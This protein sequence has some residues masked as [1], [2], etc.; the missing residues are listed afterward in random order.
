MTNFIPIITSDSTISLYN[1]VINDVYHSNVGAYTEALNKYTVPSGILEFVKSN[2]SVHIL[3]VCFGLGYNSKVAISEIWKINPNC[4]IKVTAIEIDPDVLALSCFADN[5][6]INSF[7]SSAFCELISGFININKVLN[8]LVED[9]KEY[10]YP[11]VKNIQFISPD[12]LH[13]FFK[14]INKSSNNNKQPFQ[15]NIYYK[16]ISYR[17]KNVEHLSYNSNL[18]D[19]ELYICDF[20]D[21]VNDLKPGYD[22]IFYD[23]FTP[24][25][26]PFLWTKHIFDILYKCLNDY[27]NLTTYTSAA[28]VRSGMIEAGFYVGRTDPVGK[29]TSGT[30][31]YKSSTNLKT[32][33]TEYE[34]N[35]LDTTAGI[36]YYDATFEFGSAEILSNRIMLQQESGRLSSSKY[37]KKYKQQS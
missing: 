32:P 29:K 31:A 9:V 1:T 3:D 28:P 27:G 34:I 30:I 13:L 6:N 7:C 22:Y 25:I 2:N 33:L 16:S 35:L 18:L 36:P 12:N 19:I 11:D 37:I 4:K 14:S 20:R 8:T 21:I 10:E 26:V 5:E 24:S 17:N 15:H 23:P